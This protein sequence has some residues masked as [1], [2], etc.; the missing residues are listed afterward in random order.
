VVPE[1][2]G[3]I[4]IVRPKHYYHKAPFGVFFVVIYQYTTDAII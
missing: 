4:P 1:V 2:V 3:S